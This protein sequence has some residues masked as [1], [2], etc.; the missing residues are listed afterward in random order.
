MNTT[1]I[2]I[3]PGKQ[4]ALRMSVA[5]LRGTHKKE[6]SMKAIFYKDVTVER[7]IHQG[8]TEWQN[9]KSRT[10]IVRLFGIKI[11]CKTELF[12]DV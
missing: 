4:N 11:Y 10:T 12:V 7:S 9:T 6:K 3:T 2:T 1:K 5:R 8:L